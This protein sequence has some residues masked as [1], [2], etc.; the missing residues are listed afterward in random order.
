MCE[1]GFE[2]DRSHGFCQKKK[3][4][5]TTSFKYQKITLNNIYPKLTTHDNAILKITTHYKNHNIR[6]LYLKK[7]A[8]SKTGRGTAFEDSNLH[9]GFHRNAHPVS[10]A[11]Y[12]VFT[13]SLFFKNQLII[14]LLN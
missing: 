9:P 10:A 5:R 13:A 12:P 7:G 11:K 14:A 4:I 6:L 3:H 2:P 8:T 1:T